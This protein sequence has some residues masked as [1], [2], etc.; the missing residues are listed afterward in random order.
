MTKYLDITQPIMNEA[1]SHPNT[2]NKIVSRLDLAVID[3][4]AEFEAL[5]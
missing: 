1:P 3:I 2:K 4:Y 5:E